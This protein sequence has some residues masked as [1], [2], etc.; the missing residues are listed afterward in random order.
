MIHVINGYQF[1]RHDSNNLRRRH[2]VASK[3]KSPG[4]ESVPGP[5]DCGKTRDSRRNYFAALPIVILS[6]LAAMILS[7]IPLTLARSSTDLNGPFCV[8]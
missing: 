3:Q 8:R 5:S 4:T 1:L 6:R 2:R 7:P